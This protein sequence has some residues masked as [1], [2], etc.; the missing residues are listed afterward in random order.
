MAELVK[1]GTLGDFESGVLH[2]CDV[3]G[4]KVLVT[5]ANGKI[6]AV[7]NSC[8]H[9]G[10]PLSPGYTSGSSVVCIFH[11]S[12]YDMETGEATA[13][14]GGDPL[15]VYKVQIQGEDVFVEVD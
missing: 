10:F 7:S 9:I 2:D 12:V 1:V 15:T 8:T 5:K 3:R 6:Y 4:A 14:P 11:A 13:G